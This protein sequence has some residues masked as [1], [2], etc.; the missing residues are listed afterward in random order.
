MKIPRIWG[1]PLTAP[2]AASTD[3]SPREADGAGLEAGYA[4]QGSRLRDDC[5]EVRPVEEAQASHDW[6]WR[7]G[8]SRRRDREGERGDDKGRPGKAPRRRGRT[9]GGASERNPGQEMGGNGGGAGA[10]RASDDMD[11]RE[12]ETGSPASGGLDSGRDDRR[13]PG[14]RLELLQRRQPVGEARV[15]G[16]GPDSPDGGGNLTGSDTGVT[17]PSH[18][19]PTPNAVQDVNF[20]SGHGDTGGRSRRRSRTPRVADGGESCGADDSEGRRPVDDEVVHSPCNVDFSSD[21]PARENLRW[22]YRDQTSGE[23]EPGPSEV[24]IRP[25]TRPQGGSDSGSGSGLRSAPDHEGGGDSRGGYG[26]D[27]VGGGVAGSYGGLSSSSGDGGARHGRRTGQSTGEADQLRAGAG[28]GGEEASTRA[29]GGVGRAGQARVREG[30]G[31]SGDD[32]GVDN[33]QDEEERSG[34]DD[35]AMRDNGGAN[36]NSMTAMDNALSSAAEDCGYELPEG[37]TSED[38]QCNICWEM[39]ARCVTIFSLP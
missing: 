25:V 20:S 9:N 37:L 29:D 10:G 15:A 19:G 28:V 35:D 39:L 14:A 2:E 17:Q 18:T 23:Y 12:D 3:A 21:A 27:G 26:V 31:W 30:D 32:E 33:E 4:G 5:G 8:W 38:F 1:G 7:A 34:E 11:L 6:A 16:S 13:M 36:G 24:G 22:D